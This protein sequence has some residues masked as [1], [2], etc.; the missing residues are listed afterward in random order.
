MAKMIKI[1]MPSIDNT[2]IEFIQYIEKEIDKVMSANGLCR[3]ASKKTVN[4]TSFYYRFFGRCFPDAPQA[5]KD[6][7]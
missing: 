6:D 5:E 4:E 2:T 3:V 7:E 1:A